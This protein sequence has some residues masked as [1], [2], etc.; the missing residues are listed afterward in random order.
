MTDEQRN[1]QAE[2]WLAAEAAIKAEKVTINELAD[3][4]EAGQQI[5][6]RELLERVGEADTAKLFS[7]ED[8]DK[9]IKTF[10]GIQQ[11]VRDFMTS[12][13]MLELRKQAAIFS[14]RMQEIGPFFEMVKE[15]YDKDAS[16]WH[17]P[18]WV[19]TG[20]I[21]IYVYN[22]R[23]E[24]ATE[25]EKTAHKE[26]FLG[27][28][29]TYLKALETVGPLPNERTEE[30]LSAILC[31]V[32]E[33]VNPE[34]Y[35]KGRLG[36]EAAEHL[37]GRLSSTAEVIETSVYFAKMLHT[38]GLDE[39]TK[40]SR[41][42]EIK[43]DDITRTFHATAGGLSIHEDLN[44]LPS[45]P[46]KKEQN[47]EDATARELQAKEN[48]QK[49]IFNLAG[50]GTQKLFDICA[51]ELAKMNP[52]KA[53]RPQTR[54]RIPLEDYM[55]LC[56]IPL[57]KPS[58]DKARRTLKGI[59]E[60]LYAYSL[61]WNDGKE[62]Y[63][64]RILQERSDITNNVIE[65]QYTERAAKRLCNGYITQYALPLLKVDERNPNTYRMGRR[66]LNHYSNLENQRKGTAD[67]LSVK[68]LLE[69][70]PDIPTY[71]EVAAT[72]RAYSRRIIKPFT[73]ALDGLKGVIEWEYCNAKKAPLTKHQT[74]RFDYKKFISS[75]IKFTVLNS[76]DMKALVE[77]REQKKALAEEKKKARKKKDT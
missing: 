33:E 59:T 51:I 39:L 38:P 34:Q 45:L 16:F 67:I 55:T 73:A 13:E 6:F 5:T 1:E 71:D 18:L 66:L 65:L 23:L 10:D 60:A 52:Y 74:A 50:V 68:T 4:E 21:D 42:T 32:L 26:P 14:K 47:E 29:S 20:A 7:Q 69:W 75:Y 27:F 56:G 30:A 36:Q 3:A 31:K 28:F 43:K 77:A 53:S 49:G 12:P 8:K 37:K 46:A 54:I 72:D 2:Y 24:E 25:E 41:K 15:A 40:L 11:T 76:P 61:A 9:V 57:T 63:H 17:E 70:T 22:N 48:F 35:Y 64:T 58:M 62:A 19:L 44:A